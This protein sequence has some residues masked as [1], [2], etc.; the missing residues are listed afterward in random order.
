[1]HEGK[2]QRSSFSEEQAANSDFTGILFCIRRQ[3]STAAAS[4]DFTGKQ[5]HKCCSQDI[6]RC[7]T[8][9]AKR[10]QN[11]GTSK[12]FQQPRTWINSKEVNRFHC[13]PIHL[14]Q[15]AR[16]DSTHWMQ[17]PK[18]AKRKDKTTFTSLMAAQIEYS[19][20]INS[21]RLHAKAKRLQPINQYAAIRL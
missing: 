11:D 21:E 14:T 15:H 7:K 5:A 6:K 3:H 17:Q 12:I 9:Q 19:I 1:M 13:L 18:T 10:T 20:Q 16:R 8:A 2:I 4:Y